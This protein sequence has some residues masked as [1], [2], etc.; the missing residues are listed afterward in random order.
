MCVSALSLILLSDHG[1]T[2]LSGGTVGE[3]HF[4]DVREPLREVVAGNRVLILLLDNCCGLFFGG[5]GRVRGFR[6][7][8]NAGKIAPSTRHFHRITEAH[9][10]DGPVRTVMLKAGN[11]CQEL[12]DGGRG[13]IGRW[14]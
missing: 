13:D 7:W 14:G 5:L 10:E 2:F 3:S 8:V 1:P 11:V 12:L 6:T 9:F 4:G